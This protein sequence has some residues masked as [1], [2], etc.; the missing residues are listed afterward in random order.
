MDTLVFA[1][2]QSMP[3]KIALKSALGNSYK[4]LD[5]LYSF[6]ETNFGQINSEWKFYGASYGW[7]LKTLLKK[8]NLFFVAP[9]KDFFRIAFVF[10]DRAV[11][12][13]MESQLPDSIKT[14]LQNARKYAEGRG[15]RFEVSNTE[16]LEDLKILVSIKVRN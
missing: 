5:D 13:I 4:I 12:E 10:G 6:I 9:R 15:I 2:K 7:T 8:R 14:E 11:N 3:D 16:I 1:D